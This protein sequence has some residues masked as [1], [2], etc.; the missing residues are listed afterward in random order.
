MR[1]K[2]D[3]E[4]IDRYR[5]FLSNYSS[6]VA[7]LTNNCLQKANYVQEQWQDVHM[8]E[9]IHELR[10]LKNCIDLFS[11]SCER[12]CHILQEIIERYKQ[13]LSGHFSGN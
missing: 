8:D 3:L 13:Y 4:G 2:I 10:G 5:F 1:E 11:E 9:V 12:Y 7:D 6:E